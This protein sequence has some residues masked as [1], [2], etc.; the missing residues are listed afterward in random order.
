[1]D[2]AK[3]KTLSVFSDAKYRNLCVRYWRM[4]S[5][6]YAKISNKYLS[7]CLMNE[8]VPLNDENYAESM[9]P[10]IDAIWEESPG[11]VILA[12][13]HAYNCT[14]ESMAALGVALCYHQYRPVELF[15]ISQNAPQI[16]YKDYYKNL[17]T[18]K[19]NMTGIL[20]SEDG[21]TWQWDNKGDTS[22]LGGKPDIIQGNL[23]GTMEIMLKESSV[24]KAGLLVKA[25]AKI[26]YDDVPKTVCDGDPEVDVCYSAEPEIISIPDGTKRLEI[27]CSN[28]ILTLGSVKIK[29]K[30]GILIDIPMEADNYQGTDMS[31]ITVHDDG[32]IESNHINT[33]T[34]LNLKSPWISILQGKAIADKYGVGFMCGE[35]GFFNTGGGVIWESRIPYDDLKAI[36]AACIQSFDEN[37]IPWCG[38]YRS[39]YSLTNSY[40][41]NSGTTYTN[42]AGSSLYLDNVMNKFFINMI[43]AKK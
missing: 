21:A 38:E 27:S 1:M 22:K 36:L 11:R 31:T 28:G 9:R 42:I 16:D 35:W 4:L 6:R 17:F 13:I 23:S 33:Q 5:N 26:I 30:D 39:E 25:D 34:Y 20:Y 12:D 19:Y 37:G 32:S 7:F 41:L 15:V 40:P 3:E 29:R 8:G 18:D 10:I 24:G 14:G 2:Q 43:N